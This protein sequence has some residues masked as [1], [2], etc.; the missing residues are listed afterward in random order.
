M[1]TSEQFLASDFV[2]GIARVLDHG[3]D[4]HGDRAYLDKGAGYQ[5]RKAVKHITAAIIE[6]YDPETK[7]HHACHAGARIYLC[8]DC[9][10]NGKL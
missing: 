9:L 8:W 6:G 2:Q 10:I 4:K 3:K 7:E 5:A 1:Q